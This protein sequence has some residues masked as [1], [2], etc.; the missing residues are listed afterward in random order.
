MGTPRIRLYLW[1]HR[2]LL[3]GPAFDTDLHRHHAA[4]ICVGL[5]GPLRLRMAPGDEWIEHHGFRVQPDQAHEFAAATT[6]TAIVYVEAESAEFRAMQ[7][8]RGDEPGEARFRPTSQT[9]GDL[10]R[11]YERGGDMDEANATCLSLVGLGES[12]PR[13][14]PL[15][16]RIAQ[17]LARIRARIEQPLRLAALASDINVS[18]SWLTHRFRSEIG[19]PLRRYVLWQRVWRAVEVA[20]L[21]AT[22]T[23][24]A[25]AAGL[26]DSAH[27]SRTF[28]EMFGV[29]PSFLFEHRD[30]LDVRFSA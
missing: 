25:H 20:L 30:L 1:P 16:P 21:G 9:L 26:S 24:A 5:D 13:H 22:L 14:T 6:R 23:E 27:L 3:L 28:R 29:T 12:Q 7:R 18:E 2:L 10:L 11:L 19:V 15:D 4:Q 8:L 17:C